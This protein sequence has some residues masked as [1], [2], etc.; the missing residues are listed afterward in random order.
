MKV[1]TV[2]LGLSIVLSSPLFGGDLAPN[3]IAKLL[4]ILVSRQDSVGNV[5]ALDPEVAAELSKSS[6][7]SAADAKVVWVRS[8]AD[9]ARCAKEGRLVV[10]GDLDQLKQGASLAF[11]AEGGRPVIYLHPGHLGA[12][13]VAIP[14][15]VVKLAKVVK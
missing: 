3:T 15:A 8:D 11:V 13:K 6:V 9:A 5:L 10:V 4:K 1:M 2:F 7:G 12:C 14:D